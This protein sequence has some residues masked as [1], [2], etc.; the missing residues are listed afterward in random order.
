M[1]GRREFVIYTF[2]GTHE[3]M[4]AERILKGASVPARCIPKPEQLGGGC[5]IALRIEPSKA[6][7][8]EEILTAAG[9]GWTVRATVEDD[10]I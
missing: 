6:A 10:V 2:G 9:A 8:A 4:A 3:A 7:A 5:G 1:T